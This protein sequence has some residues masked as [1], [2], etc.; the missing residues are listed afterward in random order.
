MCWGPLVCIAM[1]TTPS[2][3][4]SHCHSNQ[5]ICW[6]SWEAPICAAGHMLVK[7]GLHTLHCAC[8]HFQCGSN[9]VHFPRWFPW[10][11]LHHMHFVWVVWERVVS[12][13]MWPEILTRQP[14]CTC[15][16]CSSVPD[17]VLLISDEKW[18][19][20]R[21]CLWVQLMHSQQCQGLQMQMAPAVITWEHG[22]SAFLVSFAGFEVCVWLSGTMLQ[23]LLLRSSRQ[24]RPA[25]LKL[26]QNSSFQSCKWSQMW[27]RGQQKNALFSDSWTK[28]PLLFSICLCR[29]SCQ[30]SFL[31]DVYLGRSPVQIQSGKNFNW[32]NQLEMG[33]STGVLRSDIS[34]WSAWIHVHIMC[35]HTCEG[36]HMNQASPGG[37]KMSSFSFLLCSTR[38]CFQDI[39]TFVF[40]CWKTAKMTWFGL[41]TPVTKRFISKHQ[42][43]AWSIWENSGKKCKW[44]QMWHRARHASIRKPP[45]PVIHKQNFHWSPQIFIFSIVPSWHWAFAFLAWTSFFWTSGFTGHKFPPK[46]PLLCFHAEK[47]PK[48]TFETVINH[49]VQQPSLPTT[50]CGSD[51]IVWAICVSLALKRE[52]MQ[53]ETCANI[54]V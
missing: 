7:C 52:I 38:L 32:T 23:D 26:L 3:S 15:Q 21:T 18:G 41:L 28:L 2:L 39:G 49:V 53:W 45:I 1:E 54:S 19:R 25:L 11:F 9:W 6:I 30:H 27:E 24:P 20:G 33:P 13:M 44:S 47:Q 40:S 42:L 46:W 34:T 35:T 16:L 36:Y 17:V 22:V 37:L 10:F 8:A 51:V 14:D 12:E 4:L 43:G 50:A 29:P 48:W 5:L 31:S